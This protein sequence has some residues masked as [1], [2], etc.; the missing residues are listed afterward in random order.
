M[1]SSRP[2]DGEVK[3]ACGTDMFHGVIVAEKS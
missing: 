3:F 1:R 2:Q